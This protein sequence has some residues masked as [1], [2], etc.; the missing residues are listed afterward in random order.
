MLS[1][2]QQGQQLRIDLQTPTAATRVSA[3]LSAAQINFANLAA[4]RGA[5]LAP[6]VTQVK[7][8]FNTD[9][10]NRWQKI[11]GETDEVNKVQLD[12]RQG[13]AQTVEKVLR[14]LDAEGGVSGT[15]VADAGCG[16]GAAWR[17]EVRFAVCGLHRHARV[18]GGAQEPLDEW[19][20]QGRC[21]CVCWCSRCM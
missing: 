18:R 7:N 13:H 4:V 10:F 2:L 19:C 21:C 1:M 15:S 17:L 5:C 3:S 14:W 9:G 6:P 8:Y 16:T 12:I 20:L 11:Y